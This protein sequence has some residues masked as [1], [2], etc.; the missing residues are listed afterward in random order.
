MSTPD[1]A[2]G[3]TVNV[4]SA[5]SSSFATLFPNF[6][7]RS[8][9]CEPVA[10]SISSYSAFTVCEASS[11][12]RAQYQS[13]VVSPRSVLHPTGATGAC[14]CVTP[15]PSTKARHMFN[16]NEFIKNCASM[17]FYDDDVDGASHEK[18]ADCTYLILTCS[19]SDA[20]HH[21]RF[22]PRRATI[23]RLWQRRPPSPQNRSLPRPK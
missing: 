5:I 8:F 4:R 12:F 2:A 7:A 9:S 11:A 23:K 16:P 15:D 13:H 1:R 20:S 22:L 18:V 14:A 17:S 3:A 21:R 19:F 10:R 6:F